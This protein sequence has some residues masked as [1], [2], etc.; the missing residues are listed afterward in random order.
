MLKTVIV[1]V[2]SAATLESPAF[3]NSNIV[4]FGFSEL[5]SGFQLA[6]MTIMRELF[7]HMV[8]VVSTLPEQA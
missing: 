2:K 3:Q 1:A 4:R 6:H 7:S 5:Q 8:N